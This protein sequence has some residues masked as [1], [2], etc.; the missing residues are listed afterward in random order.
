MAQLTN[1]FLALA[2]RPFAR[3]DKPRTQERFAM[4]ERVYF[5]KAA[6]ETYQAIRELDLRVQR[7]G[8]EKALIGVINLWNRVAVGRV[9][10]GRVAVGLNWP[11]PRAA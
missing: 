6:P 2:D 11:L 8:L 3:R 10:V 9:A 4:R 7:S 5:P 1:Q